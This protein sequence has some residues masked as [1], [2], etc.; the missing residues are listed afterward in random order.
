M[1]S[2]RCIE[3]LKDTPDGSPPKCAEC[4]KKDA[5][6]GWTP[7]SVHFFIGG[8]PGSSIDKDPDAFARAL[9]QD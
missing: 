6:F 7:G 5:K 9:D 3:C 1:T 4:R 8:A 2:Q